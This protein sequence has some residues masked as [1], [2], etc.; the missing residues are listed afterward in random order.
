MKLAKYCEVE[1]KK[2]EEIILRSRFLVMWSPKR[3]FLFSMSRWW[4]C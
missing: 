3:L 2:D 1:V 4:I